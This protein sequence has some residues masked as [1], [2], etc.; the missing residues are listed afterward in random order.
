VDAVIGTPH[1]LHCL[2]F[3]YLADLDLS[4]AADDG[5]PLNDHP[6]ALESDE[7]ADPGHSD[8]HADSEQDD[9]KRH[10][11]PAHGDDVDAQAPLGVTRCAP[12]EEACH[13]LG[14]LIRG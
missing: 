7:A 6:R 8:G 11:D 13:L 2:A 4:R 10:H 12:L 1:H 9:S 3:E 5:A 14:E